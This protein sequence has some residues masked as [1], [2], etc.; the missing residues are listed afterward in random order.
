MLSAPRG[1]AA[2]TATL[3]W[4]GR[5]RRPAARAAHGQQT[6]SPLDVETYA[7]ASKITIGWLLVPLLA[8]FTGALLVIYEVR[9][10]G[11]GGLRN[12]D[13]GARSSA[14]ASHTGRGQRLSAGTQGGH[15]TQ[16]SRGRRA[17]TRT[18]ACTHARS[19]PTTTCLTETFGTCTWT[20][21]S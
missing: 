3:W 8:L 1:D 7:E 2:R 18:T 21:A 4:R 17:N 14:R 12:G 5:F 20:S 19:W 6:Y 15:A 16:L 9:C 13:E 11:C 10:Q